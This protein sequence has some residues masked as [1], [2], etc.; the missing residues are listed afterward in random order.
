MRQRNRVLT[1]A[2]AAITVAA[3]LTAVS[4]PAQAAPK[5]FF[6]Q[7]TGDVPTL[8]QAGRPTTLPTLYVSRLSLRS[9]VRRVAAGNDFTLSGTVKPAKANVV[10]SRQRLVKGKWT[11]LGSTKTDRKGRW[12]MTLTA[13]EMS[14]V[15]T[16]RAVA[17]KSSRTVVTSSQIQ[18]SVVAAVASQPTP[19][20]SAQTPTASPRPTTTRPVTPRPTTPR[21]SVQPVDTTNPDAPDGGATTTPTPS[22]APTPTPTPTSTM[23]AVGPGNRILGTDISRWQ[24]PNGAPI[25]FV[26][27]FN[28]GSRYIFIKASDGDAIEGR[29]IGHGNAGVW[30]KSDR[31]QAQAAGML[32]GFYHFAQL[33]SSNVASVITRSAKLQADLAIGRLAQVGGY[34]AKDLPYVLDIEVAPAG[35]TRT[36]ITLFSKTW[37]DEME[38]RTGKRPI[39]YASPSFLEGKTDRDAFWRNSPLWVAHYMSAADMAIRQPGQKQAGGCWATAW[40]TTSCQ[41]QWT[42]WQYTSTGPAAAYGIAAGMSNIDLNVFNGSARDLLALTT[43]AWTPTPGD[44]LPEFE[45]TR[46]FTTVTQTASNRWTVTVKVN[47]MPKNVLSELPVISGVVSATLRPFDAPVS[48]PTPTPT[49]ENDVPNAGNVDSPVPSPSVTIAPSPTPTR[50]NLP[51]VLSITKTA[52]GTWSIVIA[53]LIKTAD[54]SGVNTLNIQYTDNAR[55]HLGSSSSVTIR[56]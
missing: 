45:P 8:V 28:A 37:L 56:N 31:E 34:N 19:E 30:F 17:K 5:T 41:M 39:V 21:P 27:M 4:A 10:V 53:D 14:Q 44:F 38:R 50:A 36:S 47:R 54:S 32:T 52:D 3:G 40:T 35:V 13:P 20:A 26:K 55:I 11:T 24:H 6:L 42:F 49:V 7:R 46:M 25:D 51:R 16:Y 1:A 22:A 23:A 2:L 9:N 15:I 33:P 18:V 29:G 48:S 43:G 12:L